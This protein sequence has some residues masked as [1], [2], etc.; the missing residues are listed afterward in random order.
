[1]SP[2]PASSERVS[3]P[4]T[5]STQRTETIKVMLLALVGGGMVC[6]CGCSGHAEMNLIPLGMKDLDPAKPLATKLSAGECYY[7]LDES[8]R[9]RIAMR[10][11]NLALFGPISRSSMTLS[12]LID[13]PPAGRARTYPIAGQTLRAQ[14]QTSILYHRFRSTHGI[15][16]V[17]D[18]GSNSLRGSFRCYVRY[19][20]GNVVTGWRGAGTLLLTG[21]FSAVRDSE[22]T[23]ELMS[24]SEAG[25]WARNEEPSI[26]GTTPGTTRRASTVP[27]K[28]M[29][30]DPPVSGSSP[31]KK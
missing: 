24:E 10:Y 1:M 17:H 28:G 22:K 18:V 29:V 30:G 3:R 25:D 9:I 15:A 23:A 2:I 11:K 16:V 12:L 8:G 26:G 21:R 7:D 4:V 27:T 19:Q 14:A 20:R 6:A 13:E 31:P 5:M